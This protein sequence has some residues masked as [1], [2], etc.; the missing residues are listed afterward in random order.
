MSRGVSFP[1]VEGKLL[2][3]PIYAA[4]FAN[5]SAHQRIAR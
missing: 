2:I 3:S 1:V 4:T 5:E